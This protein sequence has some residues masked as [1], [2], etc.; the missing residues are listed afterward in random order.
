MF[1]PVFADLG[2]GMVRLNQVEMV[3]D[4]TRTIEFNL[5]SQPKKISLN[6]YKDILER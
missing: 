1:I 5:P 4:S 2:K 3:G 6:Y